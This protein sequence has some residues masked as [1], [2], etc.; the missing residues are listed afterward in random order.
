MYVVKFDIIA[1]TET[2]LHDSIANGLLD[3]ESLYHIIRKDRKA[4]VKGGGVC[5]LVKKCWSVIPVDLDDEFAD[6]EI[7]GFDLVAAKTRVRYFVLYRPPKVDSL[8][9]VYL[10]RIINCLVRYESSHTN[11]IMGD[12]NLPKINWSALSCPNDN[13]HKPFL[14]FLVESS[15]SQLVG[16][17]THAHHILDVVL[18]SDDSIF[19]YIESDIPLGASD[20]SS[21]KFTIT[22]SDAQVNTSPDTVHNVYKWNLANF[23]AIES[24]LSNIDWYSLV[25]M[26]PSASSMWDAF[27]S[28]LHTSVQLYVPSVRINGCQSHTKRRL[29]Y[30]RDMR[31]CNAKKRNLW[32]KLKLNPGDTLSRAKYLDCVH[33]WRSLIQQQELLTEQRIINANNL[34]TFY[35]FVNKRISNR[36]GIGTVLENGVELTTDCDKARAFNSYFVSVGCRDNNTTPDCPVKTDNSLEFIEFNASDVLAAINKLKSNLTCGPDGLPP[37]FFKRLRYCLAAPLAAI[38]TQLLS[39]AFVPADWKRATIVPVL[40]KGSAKVISNYRPISVTCVTCK[41]FERVIANKIRHHLTVNNILHPA[42]HGFTRG[43]STCTNLLESLNDWTLYFQDKHQ[44]AIA[45]IDFSKAFDVVSHKKLFARLSSYGIRGMLL[46]WLQQLFTGRTHCTKVGTE[47][48]EDADLL[49]GV[50]QGSVIG[51]LMFLIFI[52]ELVAILAS[53]GIVVK[54]FADDVKLYIRII[55][56]VDVSMLQEALNFLFMWAEKWQLSL[57]LDKCCVLF[58]RLAEPAV[59]FSLGGV[60][61]RGVSSCRDLGVTITSDLSPSVHIHD[62]VVK[63][64]QRSNAIHRCFLSRNV[65]VLTRAFI[66]YVRPLVEYNSIVWSPYLKQDINSI[67]SVQ[68]RF[69]KRL[70]GFGKYT[71]SKR[72][73]LLN[74]PSLELRRLYFDLT[75]AYKIIFGCVDMCSDDFFELRSTK[76]TRGHPYKLFKRQCTSTVRS[77]FFTERVVNIWNCLPSDTVDFSSLTAFK[78][79]I[80]RVDFSDFLNYT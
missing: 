55:N 79:T 45:Y 57:S 54:V 64:H 9:P 49:S 60:N 30:T 12:L 44:V 23:D 25:C 75:W 65:C 71:Y 69:T 39:V 80:K 10:G 34:G 31:K 26:H 22:L 51:P 15:Y 42:Q 18:T 36:A 8:S 21:V 24:Y 41:I 50:I 11:V 47:L 5:V 56:D 76:T 28:V 46:C 1:I 59:S 78:R 58:L 29:N 43:R 13:L 70:P 2:W 3:P 72:L 52:D 67:E 27:V 16:F 33:E 61:L 38:F 63:A 20:H 74:L 35:R 66:V 17:P 6:L 7:V 19:S 68:R 14:T 48:S 73:E 4:D 62:I 40:K 32:R 53:F 77:S 37:V